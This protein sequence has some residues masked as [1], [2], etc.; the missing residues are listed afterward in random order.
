M[1]K[2]TYV[3]WNDDWDESDYDPYTVE[4]Y[5]NNSGCIQ[6]I[7]I[8]S[9]MVA[10]TSNIFN[11]GEPT[12]LVSIIIKKEGMELFVPFDPA[13][14]NQYFNNRTRII[15]RSIMPFCSFFDLD[16]TVR[17]RNLIKIRLYNND[18]VYLVITPWTVPS[19]NVNFIIDYEIKNI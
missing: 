6:E 4:L 19:Q 1:S 16:S 11:S 13:D 2:Y 5:K 10:C 8:T 17:N 18:S 3:V 12:N 7:N 15:D 9:I 14:P